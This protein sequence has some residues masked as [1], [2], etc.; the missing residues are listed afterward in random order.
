MYHSFGSFFKALRHLKFSI[1][2]SL[3]HKAYALSSLRAIPD[4][5]SR[6]NFLQHIF[7]DKKQ[8]D[9]ITQLRDTSKVEF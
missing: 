2:I 7:H 5:V 4:I 9:Y 1:A 6:L 8:L 3:V